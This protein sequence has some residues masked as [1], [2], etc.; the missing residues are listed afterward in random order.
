M[1]ISNCL[2]SICKRTFSSKSAWFLKTWRLAST[3][4]WNLASELF[5]SPVCPAHSHGSHGPSLPL[6]CAW[7]P[8]CEHRAG[9]KGHL[10][11]QMPHQGPSALNLTVVFWIPGKTWV[12]ALLKE[13]AQLAPAALSPAARLSCRDG[14]FSWV[15]F[16]FACPH[17]RDVELHPGASLCSSSPC[18]QALLRSPLTLGSLFKSLSFITLPTWAFVVLVGCL[19]SVWWDGTSSSVF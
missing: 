14:H 11:S 18:S 13:G 7:S 1:Y 6:V 4:Y 8:L 3:F 19:G 2:I 16:Q 10:L 9:R 12:F 17:P 15:L 5:S